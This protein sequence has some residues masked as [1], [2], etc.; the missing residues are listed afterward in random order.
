MKKKVSVNNHLREKNK[1]VYL[2]ELSKLEIEKAKIAKLIVKYRLQENLSQNQLANKIG[3]TQQQIS[4]IENGEFSSIITIEKVLLA[5]GYY[6]D[7]KPVR[8]P[9]KIASKLQL[10]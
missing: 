5:L 8:L 3:V 6:L 10:A 4:K 7:I 1:N 9:Q 2:R